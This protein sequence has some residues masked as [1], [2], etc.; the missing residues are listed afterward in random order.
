[1]NE[2]NIIQYV[3]CKKD[4]GIEDWPD[5]SL[6][7]EWYERDCPVRKRMNQDIATDQFSKIKQYTIWPD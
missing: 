1:M 7:C 6:F 2:P 4:T 5:C 3:E